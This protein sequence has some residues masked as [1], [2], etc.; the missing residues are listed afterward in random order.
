MPDQTFD[1]VVVGAGIVGAS[2]AFELTKAGQRVGVI[3]PQ[4]PGSVATAA[5]M[6]HIVVMDDSPAV[7]N[8]TRLSRQ[9]WDEIAPDLPAEAVFTRP[10]TGWVAENDAELELVRSKHD[11]YRQHGIE[12]MILDGARLAA[13]EPNLRAGMLGA[14][15]IPGDA[16]VFAPAAA[17]WMI[18]AVCSKGGAFITG[19]PVVDL[20]GNSARL[21]D[22]RVIKGR[23]AVNAA[24]ASASLLTPSLPIRPRKG[25]L[26]LTERALGFCTYELIELGY[27]TSAHGHAEES[28]A[29]NVQPR[30]SGQVL[31]GSS[32]QYNSVSPDIE[33]RMIEMMLRRC[34]HFMP[35]IANLKHVRTWTG[36]RPASADSLPLIGPLPA[37]PDL[38]IAAG[39][40]GLGITGAIATGRLVAEQILG[41][42]PSIPHEPYL[43]GRFATL[44]NSGRPTATSRA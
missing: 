40:E 4:E 34:E 26:V 19:A 43:P 25:H 5:G 33:P 28:V 16:V 29:F 39:H 2:C 36:F 21:S 13:A 12:A 42:T 15:V 37:E 27:L 3:D 14:L 35:S 31:I 11:F 8:L 20:R 6:G 24:G 22:G 38:Y 23:F 7:F 10:G 1:I 18:E 17:Q 44:A 41:K 32:R 9:T 30:A